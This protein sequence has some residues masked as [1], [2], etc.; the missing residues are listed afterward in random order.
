MDNFTFLAQSGLIT[1]IAIGLAWYYK[2]LYKKP[3]LYYDLWA[4]YIIGDEK[5]VP[6]IIGNSGHAKATNVR[7]IINCDGGIRIA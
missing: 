6:I 1:L 7:L 2:E 5:I 4:P 3:K